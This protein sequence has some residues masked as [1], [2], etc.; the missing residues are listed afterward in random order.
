MSKD[1]LFEDSGVIKPVLKEG[2]C[3]K[4]P[5]PSDE[6]NVVLFELAKAQLKCSPEYAVGATTD[7]TLEEMYG[8]EGRLL[9][10][11]QDHHEECH[12]RQCG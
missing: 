12:Q 10:K 5:T 2:S 4:S 6:V 11:G 9:C 3:W 8:D 1:D 7:V